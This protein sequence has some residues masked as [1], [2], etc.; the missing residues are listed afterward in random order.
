MAIKHPKP[1]GVPSAWDST[2]GFFPVFAALLAVLLAMI[3]VLKS[4]FA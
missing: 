3:L 4:H 2:A 1:M